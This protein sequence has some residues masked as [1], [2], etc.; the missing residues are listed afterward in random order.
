MQKCIRVVGAALLFVLT[1]AADDWPRTEI[2]AGY[3]FVR[4]NPNSGFFPAFNANGG[5]GQFV[6]NFN[7]WFGLALDAGAVNKGVL[8]GFNV[9]TTVV[10]FVAGPRITIHNKSRFVPFFQTLVGGAYGTAS[11]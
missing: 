10:N 2:F 8:N 3:N 4:F 6:F 5:S 11:K 1:A 7:R 9:D